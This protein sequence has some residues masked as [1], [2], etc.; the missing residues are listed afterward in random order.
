MV[1]PSSHEFVSTCKK[2]D[3]FLILF[4]R[5][6]W[7]KNPAISLA[8]G[9]STVFQRPDFFKK[10]DLHSNI[11]NNINFHYRSNPQKINDQIFK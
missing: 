7:F 3:Y 10:W 6:S 4:L 11:A 1:M 8:E 9:I 2:S 5:Y